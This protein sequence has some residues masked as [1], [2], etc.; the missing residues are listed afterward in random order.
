MSATLDK[1]ASKKEIEAFYKKTPGLKLTENRKRKLIGQLR[2]ELQAGGYFG[3]APVAVAAEPTINIIGFQSDMP[4]QYPTASAV[5]VELSGFGGLSLNTPAPEPEPAPVPSPPTSS[6]SYPEDYS[7]GRKVAEMRDWLSTHVP[8]TSIPAKKR[9]MRDL[10]NEIYQRINFPEPEPEPEPVVAAEEDFPDVEDPW[11]SGF[12][13]D[14]DE[15]E[16]APEYE[17]ITFRG[18]KYLEHADDL[19]IYNL[20]KEYIGDWD[21]LFDEIIFVNEGKPLPPKPKKKTPYGPIVTMR[22]AAEMIEKDRKHRTFLEEFNKIQDDD[23]ELRKLKQNVA[24]AKNHPDLEGRVHVEGV[25]FRDVAQ[26]EQ[27]LDEYINPLNKE[28]RIIREDAE[29]KFYRTERVEEARQK[30]GILERVNI[31]NAQGIIDGTIEAPSYLSKSFSGGTK[32]MRGVWNSSDRYEAY[33]ILRKAGIDPSTGRQAIPI[34]EEPD[35][36]TYANYRFVPRP[37][38]DGEEAMLRKIGE[39]KLRREAEDKAKREAA[40][41]V[42]GEDDD[43]LEPTNFETIDYI[44]HVETG[45]VYNLKGEKVGDWNDDVDDIIWI[46]QK[47]REIHETARP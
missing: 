30:L 31:N 14:E 28:R 26:L 34:E 42:F 4:Q 22:E 45:E 1:W 6:V 9:E 29:G 5:D 11:G 40:G 23:L 7:K 20:Q 25:G 10:Y 36:G 44:E 27:A 37:D 3:G 15:L 19:K 18:E 46:N 13:S 2:E 16:E 24:M 47:F 12:V 8:N 32:T 41:Y 21:D 39:K 38:E 35:D 17:E 43:D 33:S